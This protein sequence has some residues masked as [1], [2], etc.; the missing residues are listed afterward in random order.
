M[1]KKIKLKTLKDI[2]RVWEDDI[3]SYEGNFCSIKE[4]REVA[5]KWVKHYTEAIEIPVNPFLTRN[6]RTEHDIYKYSLFYKIEWIK[7]FF[8]I[9]E[10]EK[11]E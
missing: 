9:E 7:H 10:K 5:K 2:E 4:L 11:D 8:S 1:N 3:E 6:E